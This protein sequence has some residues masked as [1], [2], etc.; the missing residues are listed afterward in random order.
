MKLKKSDMIVKMFIILFMIVIT[1]FC[2]YIYN[3]IYQDLAGY[4][5]EIKYLSCWIGIFS[6]GVIIYSWHKITNQVFCPYTIFMTFFFLFNYGQCI[7]WALGIHTDEEIG[8]KMLY[9]L[10]YPSNQTIIRTQ[11]VTIAYMVAFHLGAIFCH[12][13][14]KRKSVKEENNNKTL[15]KIFKVNC[16]MGSIVVVC[17]F[18]DLI[19]QIIVSKSY[20]YSALYYGEHA[21]NGNSIIILISKMLIPCLVGILIG[22]KFDKKVRRIVYFTYT[23]YSIGL[24]ICG[25]RG[26]WIYGVTVLLWLHYTYVKKINLKTVLKFGIIGFISITI[27]YAIIEVR[28]EGITINNIIRS[29]DLS[30]NPIVLV[31]NE[32]GGSMSVQ[33][34]IVQNHPV[35]PYGNTYILSILGMI[36]ERFINMLG[37]EYV[38]LTTWFSD[39]YLNINYG[40][41][42]TI[43]GEALLNFGDFTG[44]IMMILLGYIITS[45]IFIDKNDFK[46]RPYRIIFV[47]G[48]TCSWIPITRGTM[49]YSLKTFFYTVIIYFIIY[50]IIQDVLISNSKNGDSETN[51]K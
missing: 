26:G 49:Q 35:Y 48:A 40:A 44:I 45:L 10:G 17:A 4:S 11:M 2:Y 41:G 27:I 15:K 16:I 31:C 50:K 24:L 46:N 19:R 21:Y 38:G 20:G 30:N 22:S 37:I 34:A 6:F 51:E 43:V 5:K 32:M 9:K 47:A 25:D 8:V 13:Y 1:F 33:T 29:L 28:N 39:A 18:I 3:A 23:I 42:F 12:K 36:S 14:R 7:L